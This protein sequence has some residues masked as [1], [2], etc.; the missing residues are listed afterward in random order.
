MGL[1]FLQQR[2]GIQTMR[3]IK[4]AAFALMLV[5][6]GAASAQ[7]PRPAAP[8][9]PA[10]PVSPAPAPVPAPAAA[11]RAAPAATASAQG[12]VDI[13]AATEQQLDALPGVG[14]VRAKAIIAHRP[15]EELNDLVKK[16]ALTKGVLD[17]AK[18][19][20]AL[21]NVN[22]SSAKEMEKTLPG[23]GDVRSKEI[24]AGRPYATL[25]D[26]VTKGVLTQ[27]AFDKMKDVAAN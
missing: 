26:L 11:G 18:S 1:G 25:Q 21:A 13:N 15:Y 17:G 8:H 23:I 14:P 9:A 2:I 4:H 10:H 3:H 22:T 5:L 16:K 6:G 19:R 12:K 27:A 7:A 24:V 20:M